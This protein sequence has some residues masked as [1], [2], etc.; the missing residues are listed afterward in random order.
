MR[1]M[2]SYK[3]DYF[4]TKEIDGYT[5]HIELP[6]VSKED[7]SVL[8]EDETLQIGFERKDF[9]KN[10]G[11]KRY[12]LDKDIDVDK[13]SSK[14]E[15]GVLSIRLPTHSKIRARSISIN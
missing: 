8:V 3:D 9:I 10:K 13:I 5:L 7:V 4:I 11:N 14:L 15:N 1:D 6:G 12:Y 2:L